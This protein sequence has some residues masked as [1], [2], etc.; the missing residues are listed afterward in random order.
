MSLV[1]EGL[2][3]LYDFFFNRFDVAGAGACLKRY[4]NPSF[5]KVQAASSATPNVENQRD[6]K[7]RKVKVCLWKITQ[8]KMSRIS[9]FVLSYTSAANHI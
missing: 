9:R 1:F 6:K 5:F 4:T 2:I 8:Y 3:R 7:F